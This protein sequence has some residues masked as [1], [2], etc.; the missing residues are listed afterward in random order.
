MT[1]IINPWFFYFISIADGIKLLFG[2]IALISGIIGFMIEFIDLISGFEEIPNTIRSKMK[3]FII[4]CIIS[5]I[6]NIL[7]PSQTTLTQMI[8]AQNLTYENIELT[9]KQGKELID[10]ILKITKENEKDEN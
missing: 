6:L 5:V 7:T 3:F 8:I 10:Y 9:K 1:P 4:I 2:S